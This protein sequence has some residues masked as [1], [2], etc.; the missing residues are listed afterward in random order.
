M[1]KENAQKIASEMK[2]RPEIFSFLPVPGL[3]MQS[4]GKVYLLS[5]GALTRKLLMRDRCTV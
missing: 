4:F 3:D 1:L 2:R 5:F